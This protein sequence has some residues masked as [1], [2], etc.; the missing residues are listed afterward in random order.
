MPGPVHGLLWLADLFSILVLQLPS[1][2]HRRLLLFA[3]LLSFH[4]FP[5]N[6][7]LRS[8]AVRPEQNITQ[9]SIDSFSKT[10]SRFANKTFAVIQFQGLPSEREKAQL[11]AEGIELLDYLPQNAYTV[12]ISKT[13]STIALQNAKAKSLF[14]LSPQ[15]KMAASFAGGAIPSWAVKVAGTVDVWVSFY[16]TLDPA[17]VLQELKKI[18]ADVLSTEHLSY[19]I[20]A[21]RIAA[22]QVQEIASLP[23]TEF[24]QPAPS[25]DGP[26]NYNSRTGSRAN[27]LNAAVAD[28]GR[29]LNGEG[30]VIGHGDNADLQAHA[31]LSGR[32]INRNASPFNA[33]G[34]HTAGT[35]AGAGIIEELYRGYAP[36]A[37]IVS[38]AFSG[39]IDNAAL[40][41]KD[42]GMVI[43]NNSY[44]DIVE[45][46]YNGT[47]DLTSRILDQQ[48]LDLPNL[49][50][51]FA[52]GNSGLN[53]CGPYAT[54]YHTVLGGYQSAKNVLTVGA[55]TDSGAVA[56]FSSRGPV[57]DGRLKPEIT[58]MGQGVV[59]TWPVNIYSPNNGTSM[60][61]P[62]ASGGLALLYQHYRQL[63]GGANP[64][65]ALM[66]AILCN[67]TGDRGAS[68][69]DFQNGFGWMNLLRS[70]EMIESSHYF[71][72]NAVNDA[73]NMHAI[74]VPNSTAQ[75]KVLLY[76]N[77]LPA[78]V[79]STKNLV[80]DLDL[81]V[82]DPTGNVVLPLVLDTTVALLG[83]AAVQ[84]VDHSNNIEQVVINTPIAGNYTVRVKGTTVTNLQQE[85]FVAY[86][87]VP[88]GLKV[89][90]PAGDIGLLPGESTKIS[91]D[92]YGLTGTAT[93]EYSANGGTSWTTVATNVDINRVVY[94]WT[95]PS[96]ATNNALVRITK[97]TT[98][99]TATSNP[100]VILGRPNISLS[101]VQCEDYIGLDWTTV[102]GAT[103]YEVTLLRD[104]E[105]KPIATTTAKSYVIGGLSKDS[106][107]WVSVRARVNGK[108]GRRATAI[109]RQS[110]SGN[111]A[112]SISDNDVKMDAVLM[113]SGRTG[114]STALS[115]AET[116]R[117]RIKNLDD[118][119]VSNFTVSY[120]INGGAFITETIG[121]TVAAGATYVH[122]FAAPVDFFA[123]GTYVLKAFVKNLGDANAA[124]DTLTTVVKQIENSPIN[125]NTTFLDN[126]ES[127]WPASYEKD[128]VGINGDERYDFSRSTVYGRLRTFVDTS[129]ARSGSKVFTLDA[130]RY[131]PAGNVAYLYGTFN[132]SSY[133]ATTTDVRL[134]FAY[135]QHSQRPNAANRVW[136]RGSDTQPWIEV[137]NL[138]SIDVEEG[139]YQKTASIE[140]SRFLLA[141]GQDFSSSFGVR[142]GQWGQWQST[143]KE[144]AAGYTVD[145]I[146]L[147]QV[148]ND[149]QLL[150]VDSPAANNCGLSS[151]EHITVTVRNS[152]NAMQTSVPVR[153]RINGGSFVSETIPSIAGDATVQYTFST[154]ANLSAFGAYTIEAVV[155]LSS[156]T[157]KEND[158]A[159]MVLHNQPLINAFP[160][161]QNFEGSDGAF[162]TDGSRSSWQYGTPFSRKI[163]GAASGAKAWKTA[164][165]GTYHN[166][167]FSFLYS[168]CFDLT[169]MTT[170]T[171]SFSV[172]LDLEDCGTST[173]DAAWVEYSTDGVNW[174]K[175]G[176]ADTGTNWYNKPA[177]RDIWS[178][179]D[180]TRWHVATQPL[181]TG[182]SRFRFRFVMASD[183]GVSRE[184]VA[185]DDIHIYDNTSGI[186]DGPSLT[187]PV[188]QNASGNNWIDFKSGGKL[189][190]SIL[191]INQA[192]GNTDVQAYINSGNVRFTNNQYYL[193]RNLTVKPSAAPAD[194]LLIRLY[195]LDKESENLLQATDCPSCTK[196]SSAYELGIT[197][198][199]DAD[200]AMENGSLSDNQ[201]GVWNFIPSVNLAKVP[202]DKGY[203]AEAKVGN[204]SEFWFNNGG[205]DLSTPLPVKLMLFDAARQG[206]NA[207]VTWKV[208]SETNV[209]H[210]EI[211]VARSEEALQAGQF[212]KVGEVE[213]LGNTTSTQSYSFA[214]TESDKVGTRYYRLK[215]VNR[216]H[217]FRYSVVKPVVFDDVMTWQVYPN[218][219]KGA[220]SLVYQLAAGEKFSARLYDAKGSLVKEISTA[221]TG[222]LQKL[223]VDISAN[224][225]AS[226]VYLLRIN[227]VNEKRTFKLYK[228]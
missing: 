137:Y 169:G 139:I 13:P 107:Y 222:F 177:P 226:G 129:L 151:A 20:I 210:Y 67:G 58:T 89:T 218:P 53:A 133:T 175:L 166:K 47:Y 188:T 48:A 154:A 136:V 28:G 114:T 174:Q 75:L 224:N 96:A 200:K 78:S 34:L 94:T 39:I 5:Q 173:C 50:H 105:M 217:S 152:S 191:P 51:V 179:G 197:Q 115:A 31:D 214:D 161:L 56:N 24:I 167:E 22:N 33:H 73:T 101:S 202:F 228:Q 16:K 162:Y 3:L 17:L 211:E 185:I 158:T 203:Y 14:T 40:Y 6:I 32:L 36:K 66:K 156:D 204:F 11:A 171:L 172:A 63:N 168:P 124:N 12:A 18:N 110:N 181:P 125:L 1:M 146:Q 127:A 61:A 77:D 102:T 37:T 43:T 70:V 196:P 83:N 55:T 153:Y 176:K 90:A 44:G 91:W 116:V 69:P 147:Y 199:T 148:L 23:F 205:P 2:K 42:Y 135:M 163:R 38:Q 45:C 138:D 52:A 65:N 150:H 103:D 189:I 131:V 9:K 111:C 178:V 194:S 130:N 122:S 49:I 140:V 99:E 26:L 207:L 144:N 64:K 93:L 183:P 142:W 220:F 106:V 84:G 95:A 46:D 134:D 79:V 54:G 223:R 10:V 126:I 113:K 159:T 81:E 35:L 123:A 104:G 25:K 121:T 186:Y 227:A 92:S 74:S 192:L 221:A 29:G 98:G 141:N 7:F 190:A 128:T 30:I 85:Y 97:N 86:D 195:F 21:L 112:G 155:D 193:D 225:Y 80:N 206:P 60:A 143:D 8:G 201:Q 212:E 15:Q 120:S 100:F 87:A 219:S 27:L 72:G 118:A 170:P 57:K 68:G 82:A 209:L 208:G 215:V 132:L 180:Y 88:T 117:V 4:S 157:F 160:Y 216:D 109:A 165:Q 184:G 76:W 59:S 182:L 198:Y 41:A 62:A 119:P 108:P 145:D 213:S 164:L 187:A 19:R 71:S 149:V